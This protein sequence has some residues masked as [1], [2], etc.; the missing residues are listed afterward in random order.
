M[1]GLV[2][3][4]CAQDTRTVTEPVF[5]PS[6]AVLEARVSAVEES[7]PDT[8]RIQQALDTCAPGRAV[9]L[10][11]SGAGGA[12]ISGPLDLRAGVTLRIGG[13]ATLFG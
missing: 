7:Q 1:F 2:A 8:R 4:A 6:C 12:F 3:G 13:G 11:P 10:R 5:P 9:E